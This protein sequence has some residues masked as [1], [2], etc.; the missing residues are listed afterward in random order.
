MT[1]VEELRQNP[2]Q[3]ARRLDSE[4]R[5]G[6]TTLARRFCA[7]EGDAAELVNRTFA[8]VVAGIDRYAEQSAFFGWMSR[9]LVNLHAKDVR[10]KSNET[11]FADSAFP[12]AEP[13]PESEARIYRQ[14]DAAILRDAVVALPPEM[15]D[16][17]VLRYFLDMPLARMAKILAV[18]EGTVNSRL[19]YA[20][21]ALA[22]SAAFAIAASTADTL[23]WIG[24]SSGLLSAS[25][26]WTSSGNHSS[27]QP[28]DTCVFHSAVTLEAED[29]D[30][31][32]SGLTLEN[33]AT[34]TL[35]VLTHFAGSG[36]I[37]K[38]GNGDLAVTSTT[39]GTFT[40][41]VTIE[42]GRLYLA[43]GGAIRFGQGKIIFTQASASNSFITQGDFY[44]QSLQN[45]VEFRGKTSNY[46]IYLCRNGWVSGSISSLHDLV[47]TTRRGRSATPLMAGGRGATT[48]SPTSGW[49]RSA[50]SISWVCRGGPSRRLAERG[51]FG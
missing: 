46:A 10:R 6:L 33:D 30:L 11:V 26:N 17:V 3:G 8:E 36:G 2:Q 23:T 7:D 24:G 13:D 50:A 27:P 16:A 28:G 47:R 29:F 48:R 43:S 45:D 40:G 35:T 42:A 5:A 32:S 51:T 18:P 12:E 14:V 9:I 41:D 31:G 25:S 1:I 44:S 34:A 20:R 49:F 37:T 15:R 19:H 21:L 4:Y 22:A 38:R 39:A